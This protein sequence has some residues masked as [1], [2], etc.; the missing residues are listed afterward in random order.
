M[1]KWRLYIFAGTVYV[2]GAVNYE[3]VAVYSLFV[4]ASDNPNDLIKDVQRETD[5]GIIVTI[6]DVND[7]VPVFTQSGVYTTS[8][9][10]NSAVGAAVVTVSATDGDQL[11]GSSAVQVCE[12]TLLSYCS[13]LVQLG[14]HSE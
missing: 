9:D 3:V 14:V 1:L 11:P 5:H 8:V 12:A 2:I 7:H 6:I 10:E 13:Y 4:R